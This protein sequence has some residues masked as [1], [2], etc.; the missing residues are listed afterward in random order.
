[1]CFIGTI[2]HFIKPVRKGVQNLAADIVGAK[3]PTQSLNKNTTAEADLTPIVDKYQKTEDLNT[4][5]TTSDNATDRKNSLI[6]L[7]IPLL[8]TSSTDM[9][10]GSN[11]Y[12][13]LNLGGDI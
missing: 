1:M 8:N 2:L 11:K 10:T 12:L 3:K 5:N 7:K 4:G 13:G 9:N 6:A